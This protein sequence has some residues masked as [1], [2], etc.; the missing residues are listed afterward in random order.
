MAPQLQEQGV[1]LAVV[2]NG[3]QYFAS[4]FR[5]NLP[6]PGEIYLDPTSSA[7]AAINLPR[8]SAFQAIKHFF[9]AVSWFKKEGS[10]YKHNM[11]GD[12]LQTGGVFLIGPG[13][14][15]KVLFSFREADN[16]ALAFADGQALVKVAAEARASGL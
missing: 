9:P 5:E 2:G 7:F 10:K 13:E 16:E 8:M 12:G 6:W 11:E 15:S 3:S 1:K 4:Q 14:S